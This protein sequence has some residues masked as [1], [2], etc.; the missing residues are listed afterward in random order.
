MKALDP[1]DA[2]ITAAEAPA[3][4]A[5]REFRVTI[6]STGRPGAVL[7]PAN[8]SD[9]EIA[10]FAGWLLTFVMGTFRAERE[11]GPASRILVPG[12]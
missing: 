6:R 5:M 8:A 7:L 10:E 1:I 9:A 2:A 12:H 3:P 4:V 11:R